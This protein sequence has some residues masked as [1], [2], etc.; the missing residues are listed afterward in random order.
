[1]QTWL[2]EK[3]SYYFQA[4]I[5]DLLHLAT[6]QDLSSVQYKISRANKLDTK[7]KTGL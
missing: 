1:M 3:A 5:P 7:I 4:L 6:T 2:L